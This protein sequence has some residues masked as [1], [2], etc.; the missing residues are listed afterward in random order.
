MNYCTGCKHYKRE[1]VR[2]AHEYRC[3]LSGRIAPFKACAA[4]VA[5]FEPSRNT[6]ELRKGEMEAELL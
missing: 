3:K 4:F 6:C 1:T 2:R 5:R